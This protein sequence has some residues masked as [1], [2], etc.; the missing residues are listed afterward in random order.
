M[1]ERSLIRSMVVGLLL[2]GA[3]GSAGAV[4]EPE[5]CCCVA[6]TGGDACM[7]MTEKACLARQQAA[8]KYDD[9]TKYDDAVKKSQA[10]EA[11]TMKSGWKEGKCPAMK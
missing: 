8:P 1:I 7:E 9:K 4:A 3:A 2:A 5:G 10:E 6:G 11:G